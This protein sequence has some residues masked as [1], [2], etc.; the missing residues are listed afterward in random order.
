M[1]ACLIYFGH[2]GSINHN[3]GPTTHVEVLPGLWI[4]LHAGNAH[5]IA[6]SLPGLNRNDGLFV[7]CHGDD[8]DWRLP[9]DPIPPWTP[10]SEDCSKVVSLL[11]KFHIPNPRY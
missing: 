1:P 5:E 9:E 10:A 8:A 11:V 3:I 4:V 2:R 7:S 6:V